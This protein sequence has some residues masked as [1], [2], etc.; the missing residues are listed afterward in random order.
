MIWSIRIPVVTEP[1][2]KRRRKRQANSSEIE[3]FGFDD[4]DFDGFDAN[5]EDISAPALD[6]NFEPAIDLP[7]G[8]QIQ[9][10]KMAVEKCV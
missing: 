5:F 3:S 10:L 7:I 2:T 4:F 8:K 9:K 6:P 1:E